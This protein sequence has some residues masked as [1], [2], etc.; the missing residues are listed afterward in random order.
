ML[1]PSFASFSSSCLWLF[2]ISYFSYIFEDYLNENK[3]E[4]L[5][6]KDFKDVSGYGIIGKIAEND[7][8]LG[9]SKILEKYDITNSHK[10]DEEKLAKEGNSI[11]YVVINNEISAIIGVNDIV[12]ENSKE[13]IS[14]LNKNK[15]E[16]VMLTGD[17]K[18]TAEKIAKEIGKLQW[19]Q[20]LHHV[21]KL[22]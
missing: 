12:R 8:I 7:V 6:V 16:T 13:V 5:D 2:V 9:N 11:I 19:Y 3:I 15:I 18:Q 20:T 21:K 1:F 10:Q 14:K 4:T 17:N 22:R